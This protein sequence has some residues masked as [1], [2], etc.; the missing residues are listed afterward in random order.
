MTHPDPNTTPGKYP[1]PLEMFYHWESATPD[2]VYLRQPISD[3]W[4]TWTWKEAGIEIRKMAAALRAMRMPL[5]S[6]VAILSKNCAHWIM[7]DL[8]IMMAGHVSVPL[9]PNLT[10]GSIRQILE[11]CDAPLLFVGKLDNWEGMKGGVPA[12]IQ[13]I[14][15]PFYGPKGYLQWE[16]LVFQHEPMQGHIIRD[17]H[18]PGTLIYTSGSTGMPKGVMHKISNFSFAGYNAIDYLK[19][20]SEERFFSYLPMAHIGERFFVEMGSLYTGG[21]ISFA[22][23]VEKF[24]ENVRTAK[25]TIFLGVHRIWKK[26][27]EG[28]LTHLPEKRLNLLLKIPFVSGIIKKKIRKGL[29]FEHTRNLFTSAAPTPAE[30]L[31]WYRKIGIVIAEGWAMTETFAYGTATGMQDAKPG[32]VGR[33]LPH[34]EMKLGQDGELLV[35]HEALMDG[36]YKDAEQTREAFTE[37]GFLRTGDRAEFN[38]DGYLKIIGRTKEQFK[39]SKGKYVVPSPIEMKV[40]SNA[41]IEMSCVTGS[42]LPQPIVIVTLTETG[43]AK[44]KI[45][46]AEEIAKHIH[47]INAT[48]DHHEKIE[49]VIIVDESWTVENNMLTPTMKLKRREIEDKYATQYIDWYQN[50]D[51]VFSV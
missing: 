40:G 8:A 17:D 33:V 34:A 39:T 36:Y 21:E 7:C 51:F 11:H 20:T 27:Q 26:I 46:M 4:R 38:S 45:R 15:F 23:S 16:K 2:K 6:H 25:P 28:I 10:A 29:G 41:D 1:S 42:S 47:A 18:E 3:E 22:E 50:K 13:C 35:K 32:Y 37:D 49:K 44:D 48:L 12:G 30:L 43:K 24:Q 31:I 9:Y 5:H 19:L 14:S